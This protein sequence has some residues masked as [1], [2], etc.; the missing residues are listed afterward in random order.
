[1]RLESILAHV[2]FA[3]N[4]AGERSVTI[5]DLRMDDQIELAGVVLV[6]DDADK[7]FAA[8]VHAVVSGEGAFD[9]K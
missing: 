1:M 6:A 3:A 7:R 5:V 4:I 2:G 9:A 8:T